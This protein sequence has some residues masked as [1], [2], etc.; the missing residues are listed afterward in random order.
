[1]NPALFFVV[2][3]LLLLAS[4]P[5]SSPL[6]TRGHVLFG[7]VAATGMRILGAVDF[8]GNRHKGL[9]VAISLGLGMIPLIAL[10]DATCFRTRSSR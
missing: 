10:D 3:V 9:I 1:M 6:T 8:E 7:I 2:I 4:D 5:S